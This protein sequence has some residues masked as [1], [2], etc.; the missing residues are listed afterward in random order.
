MLRTSLT[1]GLRKGN[2]TLGMQ[3]M[4]LWEPLPAEAVLVLETHPPPPNTLNPQEA[5]HLLF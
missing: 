4:Y 5:C 3:A 1:E 2:K